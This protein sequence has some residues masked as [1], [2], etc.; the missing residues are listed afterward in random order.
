MMRFKEFLKVCYCELDVFDVTNE[1][2]IS[3]NEN[4]LS[5]NDYLDEKYQEWIV[6]DITTIDDRIWVS[7]RKN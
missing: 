2:L 4:E 1:A 5:I 3:G 6:D 7:I